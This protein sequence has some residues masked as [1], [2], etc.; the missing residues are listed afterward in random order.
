LAQDQ[1][2]SFDASDMLRKTKEERRVRRVETK[3]ATINA[4]SPVQSR[5]QKFI[6]Q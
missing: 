6:E 4:F 2:K 5:P 3:N 1:I